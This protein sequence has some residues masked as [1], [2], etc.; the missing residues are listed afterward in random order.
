[1]S[2]F[3]FFR[4]LQNVCM[5]IILTLLNRGNGW[6]TDLNDGSA[7]ALRVA[8]EAT[9]NVSSCSDKLVRKT[10]TEKMATELFYLSVL[11]FSLCFYIYLSSQKVRN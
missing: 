2:N 7:C 11:I 9:T 4:W 1:M 6:I 8:G 5:M 10:D 3:A